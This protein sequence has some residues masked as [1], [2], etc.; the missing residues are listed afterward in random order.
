[1]KKKGINDKLKPISVYGYKLED[2]LSAFMKVKPEDLRK[3]KEEQEKYGSTQG[4]KMS[5]YLITYD[6]HKQKK[7]AYD[8]MDGALQELGANRIFQT[9]WIMES[10]LSA[11]EVVNSLSRI[12][13]KRGELLVVELAGEVESL[14]FDDDNTPSTLD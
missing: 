14:G 2:V 11:K 13:K 8:E 9:V 5:N 7:A 4:E 12:V 1:M 10:D 3:V 6:F